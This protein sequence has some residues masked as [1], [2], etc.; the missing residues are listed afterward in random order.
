MS[1]ESNPGASTLV[2]TS[3]QAP[4][5]TTFIAVILGASLIE[6][7]EFLFP[8]KIASLD[9]SDERNIIVLA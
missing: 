5:I 9:F 3:P 4:L 8:P 7:N 1:T 6:F 2:T